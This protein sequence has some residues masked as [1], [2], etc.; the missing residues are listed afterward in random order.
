MVVSRKLVMIVQIQSELLHISPLWQKKTEVG[1]VNW[2]LDD[3][4]VTC[5]VISSI[6]DLSWSTS[7]L[8]E[9]CFLHPTGA[10]LCC[11][12]Q[13]VSSFS[14]VISRQALC[15]VAYSCFV[16][17]VNRKCILSAIGSL[18]LNCSLASICK[19]GMYGTDLMQRRTWIWVQGVRA[20]STKPCTR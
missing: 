5:F 15:M 11:S 13:N 4:T 8:V 19:S 7:N 6:W 20:T 1:A 14:T 17:P 10:T 2:H 9:S 18:V 16:S 3:C 12:L